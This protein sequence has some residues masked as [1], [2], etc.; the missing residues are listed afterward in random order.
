MHVL[1]PRREAKVIDGT[2]AETRE[3]AIDLLT[4]IPRGGTEE[5]L[6]A[7]LER[8]DGP[9]RCPEC[10]DPVRIRKG[11]INTHHFAHIPPFD[12]AYGS[13]ESERHYLAKL[14][15]YRTLKELPNCGEISVERRRGDS[16]PDVSGYIQEIDDP[17][18]RRGESIDSGRRVAIEVQRSSLQMWEL[19]ERTARY[20]KYGAAVLWLA[21]R[22][23][24]EIGNEYR[25]RAWERWV[26]GLCFGRVYYWTKD[27]EVVPVHFES[28]TRYVE[29]S[30][31]YEPGGD[32]RQE[33][34]Y[35]RYL[36]RIKKPVF[37]P[38][39]RIS[40]MRQRRRGAWGEFPSAVLWQGAEGQFWSD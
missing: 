34:G 11:T 35:N 20:A 7:N 26:H 2:T 29:P 40:A 3:E 24:S 5:R 18:V 21:V 19:A 25:P 36:K 9:F 4:A 33:G 31:W 1:A 30:E 22:P 28:M 37:G 10:S 6:A 32:L 14:S 8:S 13:E 39:T 38:P 23:I 17:G 27:D 16:R 15:I 12:C